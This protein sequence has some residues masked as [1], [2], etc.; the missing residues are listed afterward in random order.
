MEPVPRAFNPSVPIIRPAAGPSQSLSVENVRCAI[1][2][3]VILVVVLRYLRKDYHTGLAVVMGLLVSMP[4]YLRVNIGGG[5][6]EM[7][8]QR[9]LLLLLLA[10]WWPRRKQFLAQAQVPFRPYLMALMAV[11][12]LS[13]VFSIEHKSS[14]K[15][16]FVFALETVLFFTILSTSLTSKRDIVKVLYGVA[17]GLGF[18]ALIAGYERREEVN[19]SHLYVLGYD[20][21]SDDITST[22][23]HRIVLGY[24][25][26]MAVPVI[27]V[28]RDLEN[29]RKWKRILMVLML[30]AFAGCYFGNSR[31]PWSGLLVGTAPLVLLGSKDT[32]KMFM[33]FGVLGLVVLLIRPGVRQTLYSLY[34][35][36]FLD[37][38][39]DSI[40]TMSYEYRWR[41]WYVAYAEDMKS[42]LRVLFGYG[43]LSTESMDLSHY[44]EQGA[45]GNTALLGHTSWDNQM[46]CDLI[47]FG[48]VGF[49]MEMLMLFQVMLGIFKL[50]RR[51]RGPDKNFMLAIFSAS[52]VYVYALTNVYI[53][54]PQLKCLFWGLVA[55]GVRYGQLTLAEKL[56]MP[57]ATRAVPAAAPVSTARPQTAQRPES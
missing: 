47:E 13:F 23:P 11:Q 26:A 5:I 44:F 17:I 54:S 19:L 39:E 57:A 49:G 15:S 43:G 16:F 37:K 27:M 52:G 33:W 34:Y 3:G 2:M 53:F 48:F 32:K 35:A 4:D 8:I 45:G 12:F 40:K 42:P 7:T 56:P 55:C 25:M 30:L 28:V 36:T 20:W 51:M 24:A 22:Y 41:L 6:P 18:V 21:P 1:I 38:E 14:M 9:V 46:A 29:R 50:W 31:G 10:F